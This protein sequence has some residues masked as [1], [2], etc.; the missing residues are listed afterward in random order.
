[1]ICQELDTFYA[2]ATAP[3]PPDGEPWSALRT[4]VTR[5]L[6]KLLDAP[7]DKCLLVATHAGPMRAAL[8]VACG[9]PFEHTWAFRISHGTRLTLR[10]ERQNDG[11]LWGEIIEIAQP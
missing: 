8:S 4:R 7:G 2:C 5:A 3:G 1:M 11:N 6:S 10:V 9:I